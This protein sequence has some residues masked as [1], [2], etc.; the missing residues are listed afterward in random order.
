MGVERERETGG[1]VPGAVWRGTALQVLGRFW[2]AACTLAILWLANQALDGA[3]FGRFTFYIALF[4]WLDSVANMGTGQVAV[5]R[6]AAAPGRMASVLA[7]ARGIRVRAGLFGVLLC[8]TFVLSKD[9]PDGAWIV[10]ASLYPVTHALELSTI[11]ARNAL[12]WSVPVAV[13]AIAAALSLA[14]VAVLHAADVHR[15]ALYLLGVALGSTAGNV[16]LHLASRRHFPVER[17]EATSEQGFFRQALP[18]G[19]SALCAQTYFYVDNL[20]I[21]AWCGLEPLGHYNVAVRVMSW[22]I[23]LAQYTTLT[24]LPWLRREQLAGALGPA[25]ARLGPPL[26]AGAGLVCGLAFAWTEPLL[27]LFGDEFRAASGSLRWLLGATTA[28][29]A[30]SLF[31]TALVALGKNVASLWIAALGVLLNVGLNF[32]AVPALGI[33]G[34]ALTTF[35]TEAFVTLAGALVILRSGVSLGSPWRWLG[36]PLGFAAGAG[37][38]SLLAMGY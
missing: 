33:E 1:R 19:V 6:T 21:E 27:G 20:F 28:I 29:Y 24:V 9:E 38:S 8:A 13:R 25:L 15:P 37:L 7:A 26:F 3:G 17:G 14:N 18:L 31:M 22:S 23:M 2:G 12:S 35:A 11:P 32:W 30:G 10:L 4:A 34:A 36:G 5:Q 16:L